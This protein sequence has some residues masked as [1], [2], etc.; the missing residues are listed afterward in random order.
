MEI[1]G[2]TR[3]A[4]VIANPIKHSLSPFIHNLAFE[5]TGENGVY[6]AWELKENEP[7]DKKD[8]LLKAALGNI[9]LL[10]MYGVNLS[11]PYKQLAM[12]YVNDLSE[13]AKLIGAINTI[14]NRDGTLIGHNTD[15]LGF[16]RM[17]AKNGF[18]P[19]GESVVVL[20][21]GG[22]ALA[23]IAEAALQSAS[24]ITVLARRSASFQPLSEKLQ[25]LSALTGIKIELFDIN[26][27]EK[28]SSAVTESKIVVNATSVGM[29]G[30]SSPLASAVKFDSG[31]FVADAIYKI[32]ETPFL[33]NAK[34]QGARTAN[35]V[36]MLLY[37]AAESFKLWTGKDM[38]VTA[39]QK[40][41]E[42]KL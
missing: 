31:Q 15:G 30:L 18:R 41:L 8:T 36:G 10:N 27:V 12:W 11:M 5:L 33:K 38:P 6:T 40:E 25:T 4:A 39:I 35:G 28:T 26:Q 13:S 34:S 2:Y 1:N 7:S 21:G 16:W 32:P 17:A 22:A 14:E 24:K 37:Q 29:D 23:I 19:A 42:K 20:G 9:R 3:M